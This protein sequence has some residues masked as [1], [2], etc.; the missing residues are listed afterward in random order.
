MLNCKTSFFMHAQSKAKLIVSCM[1][2]QKNDI[3]VLVLLIFADILQYSQAVS[4][5]LK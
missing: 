4:H 3:T 5:I 1:H 2:K